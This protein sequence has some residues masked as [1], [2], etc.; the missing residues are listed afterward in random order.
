M[1]RTLE[2][3]LPY[4]FISQLCPQ[5]TSNKLKNYLLSVQKDLGISR[6]GKFGQT[7]RQIYFFFFL[8]HVTAYLV[9]VSH[10]ANSSI[11]MQIII[12]TA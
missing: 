10:R 12:S 6:P 3:F 2:T 11:V 5:F 8:P 1:S 7:D 4:I 9:S